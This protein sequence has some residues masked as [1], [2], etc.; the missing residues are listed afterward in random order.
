M[1]KIKTT[2]IIATAGVGKRFGN[3]KKNYIDL[4]GKPVVARTIQ[5]F[6]DC[7]DV[8]SIVIVAGAGDI[9]SCQT[10]IVE[11]YNFK[12]VIKII[13]GGL[14]RQDSVKNGFKYI[15]SKKT[16][17]DIVI[18]HDG[19]RPLVTIGLITNTISEAKLSGS[20]IA[21]V[22][23]KDTIKKVLGNKVLTTVPRDSLKSVQTPQ[24]FKVDILR[25]AYEFAEV[26]NINGTDE[27][28]LVEEAGFTVSVVDGS[29]ENIKVTTPED[30]IFAQEIIKNRTKV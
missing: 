4:S 14:E 27:S 13:K 20:A 11:K 22:D 28:M 23:V 26:N 16:A 3:E 15:N 29:Y 6:Q 9:E 19:G 2:A 8:D 5:A 7:P 21:A 24:A 1:K 12:K 17:D 10:D 25:K 18:I 30:L